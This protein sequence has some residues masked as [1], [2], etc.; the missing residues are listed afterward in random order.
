MKKLIYTTGEKHGTDKIDLPTF[1]VI[2]LLSFLVGGQIIVR[3][4]HLHTY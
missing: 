1:L 3:Q 4:D 2:I